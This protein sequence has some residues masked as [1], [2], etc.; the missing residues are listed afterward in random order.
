MQL[1]LSRVLFCAAALLTAIVEGTVRANEAAERAVFGVV[2]DA[3]GKPAAGAEVYLAEGPQMLPRPTEP[4][5][6]ALPRPEVVARAQS[7]GQGAFAIPLTDETPENHWARTWLV[8]W[9]HRPG[10]ALASYLVVRDWPARA[11]AI[12]IRLAAAVS[13]PLVVVSPD[14]KPLPGVRVMPERVNDLRLP[15]EVAV[16]LAATSDEMGLVML[17]DLAPNR[18]DLVRLESADYG[19][20]WAALPA[21]AADGKP[22]IALAPVGKVRGRLMAEDSAAIAGR[23]VRLV[24]RLAADEDSAGGGLAE[25]V[26]DAEGRFEAPAMAAGALTVTPELRAE[27]PLRCRPVVGKQIVAGKT[28]ELTIPLETAIRIE[29][30]VRDRDSGAPLAGAALYLTY[31]AAPKSFPTSDEQGRY[32]DFQLAGSVS[33]SPW[34]MPR[35]YYFPQAVLETQ[36]VPKGAEKVELKP[37]LLARGVALRGRVIGGQG[38][39][40]AGAEVVGRW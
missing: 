12:E 15:A 35:G 33:P 16:R 32:H 3:E 5:G 38:R 31:G 22:Q 37:L 11:A 13:Q 17:V 1:P 18:L 6:Q 19:V 26:I 9:V 28:A 34:R 23:S 8:L 7:D 29:G 27:L 36:A 20:Q 14:E 4:G 21:S 39:S 25:V 10:A 30:V 40:V 2:L 24:S